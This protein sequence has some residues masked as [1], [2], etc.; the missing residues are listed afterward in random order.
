MDHLRATLRRYLADEPYRRLPD[1]E[2][3]TRF[4]DHREEGAF[5]VFLEKTGG[6]V[7]ALSQS[8]LK[9]DAEAEEAFQETYCALFRDRS[10]LGSYP[11]AVAWLIETAKNKARMHR[12]WRLRLTWRKR[13]SRGDPDR[14]R[15]R[16]GERAGRA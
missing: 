4:R 13:K 3:W 6:I 8:V 5:R 15:G 12:R 7:Y 1:D 14:R 16:S 2:L 9:N 11:A 10:K